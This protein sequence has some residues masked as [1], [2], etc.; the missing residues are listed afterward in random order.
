MGSEMCIRDSRLAAL[1]VAHEKP[2][3]ALNP[4]SLPDLWPLTIFLGSALFFGFAVGRSFIWILGLIP[5]V[6]AG[7]IG[8]LLLAYGV[9]LFL[10]TTTVE[11]LGRELHIR[12]TCLGIGR[13]RVIPASAIQDFQLH[14]GLQA[15]EQVWYDLKL[16]LIDGRSCISGSGLEKKEAEWLRVELQKALGISKFEKSLHEQRERI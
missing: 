12:S 1:R 11:V 5:L 14:A 13:S 8:L 6:F 2:I 15:G 16:K 3:G 10:G 4:D 9:W 7:G